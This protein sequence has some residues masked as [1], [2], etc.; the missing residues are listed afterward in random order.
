M[1]AEK[2]GALLQRRTQHAQRQ[3]EIDAVQNS[4]QQKLQLK[5]WLEALRMRTRKGAGQRASSAPNMTAVSEFTCDSAL[6]AA[7]LVRLHGV[8]RLI[9]QSDTSDAI[10]A[11]N[12]RVL[13][14]LGQVLS[15]L[16]S[17]GIAADGIK[18]REIVCRNRGRFDLPAQDGELFAQLDM[19]WHSAVRAVLGAGYSRIMSGVIVALPGAARQAIHADGKPLFE[20]DDFIPLPPHC[21]SVFV[22]LIDLSLELGPT[23][24]FPGSHL[25]DPSRFNEVMRGEA[26][27][28]AFDKAKAGDA[29]IFDYRIQ[30]RGLANLTESSPR[31]L[32]YF[33]YAKPWFQDVT[34]Y[35]SLSIFDEGDGH[36]LDNEPDR[37]S[38]LSEFEVRS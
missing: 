13:L 12:E 31:P 11:C 3:E 1:R 35:S 27:G 28:V 16:K 38:S 18:T 34:N 4:L 5:L 19:Y 14:K 6:E 20:H 33:T 17:L 9:R 7:Q 30:H 21:L 15:H 24:F 37:D 36:A 22:P 23:E 26:Q 2:I 32:L 25:H 10:A 8:C 29:I